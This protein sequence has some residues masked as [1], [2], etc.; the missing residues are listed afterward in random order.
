MWY[1]TW[2]DGTRTT[3]FP[4][5]GQPTSELQVWRKDGFDINVG[6]IR[7][8][9]HNSQNVK[10]TFIPRGGAGSTNP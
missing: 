4:D 10:I 5:H 1:V 9:D 3:W 8:G 6:K 2:P 7:D